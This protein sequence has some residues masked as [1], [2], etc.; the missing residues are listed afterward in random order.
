MTEDEIKKF[1]AAA[2]AANAILLE[3]ALAGYPRYARVQDGEEAWGWDLASL[4]GLAELPDPR[5]EK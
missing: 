3:E 4:E 2:D 1:N 5:S